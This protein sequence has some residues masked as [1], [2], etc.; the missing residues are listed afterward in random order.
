M[1][2]QNPIKIYY[3]TN[4]YKFPQQIM[5]NNTPPRKH[6]LIL[7]K[8]AVKNSAVRLYCIICSFK[9]IILFE[10]YS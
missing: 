1:S 6:L 9:I 2:V 5:N 10:I 8:M 7:L 4:I 3:I